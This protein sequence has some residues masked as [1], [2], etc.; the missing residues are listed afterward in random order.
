MITKRFVCYANLNSLNCPEGVTDQHMRDFFVRYLEGRAAEIMDVVVDR[1]DNTYPLVRRE[2][3][4]KVQKLCRAQHIDSIVVPTIQMLEPA[5][6]S[7]VGLNQEFKTKFG[8][9]FVFLL[10]D[11]AES[12]ENLSLAIQIHA[13][14]MENQER[15]KE[16]AANMHRA[17]YEVTGNGEDA[18]A[19]SV[20][21]DYAL[22]H[23][24]K[25]KAF[26][27]G[28]DVKTLVR[29][30]LEFAIDPAN[31]QCV[32]KYVYGVESEGK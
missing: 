23:K 8:T 21:V 32:D 16:I 26:A 20:Y 25:K 22:Y 9:G 6:A 24:A 2:G 18:S 10:E 30:L 29:Y 15:T 4:I 12:G 14:F 3:W 1:Y 5:V 17:F 31:E 28:D 13:L 11:I 19:V 7:L 27:Y